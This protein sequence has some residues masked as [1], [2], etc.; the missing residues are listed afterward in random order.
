[1]TA[2]SASKGRLPS[3]SSLISITLILAAS[4]FVIKLIGT[5]WIKAQL[6]NLA[7][8]HEYSYIGDDH[9]EVWPIERKMVLMQMGNP[10]NIYTMDTEIGAAEWDVAVPGDSGVVYLGPHKQPYTVGLM[11]QLKCLDILRQE[12]IKE[13]EPGE[14]PS[15]L[16][17]HCLNY[18]RQTMLCRG[19]SQIESFDYANHLHPVDWR[20]IYE[21]RDWEAVYNAVKENQKEYSEWLAKKVENN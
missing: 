20:G 4:S 16:G 7:I 3:Q 13:R 19:D 11:H 10:M 21:C 1:M 2:P 8:H 9:P 14:K 12:T 5:L 17:R 15:E 18:V 6:G